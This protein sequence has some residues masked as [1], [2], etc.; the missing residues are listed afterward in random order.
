MFM[1][2]E[3]LQCGPNCST[4]SVAENLAA[5]FFF[6]FTAEKPQLLLLEKFLLRLCEKIFLGDVL[7]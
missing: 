2:V 5:W 6:S 7:L 3:I 4:A 1:T